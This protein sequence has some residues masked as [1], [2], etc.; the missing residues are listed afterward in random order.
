MSAAWEAADWRVLPGGQD[1][2]MTPVREGMISYVN[3][4]DHSLALE[5]IL[6]MNTFIENEAHNRR[7]AQRLM[8]EEN[9]NHG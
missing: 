4:L 2:L 7:V 5:D 8:D 3:L 9:R 6:R 1:W